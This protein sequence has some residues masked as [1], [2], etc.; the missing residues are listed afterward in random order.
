ML[1]P[2]RWAFLGSAAFLLIALGEILRQGELLVLALPLV[3]YLALG[4][5][6]ALPETMELRAQRRVSAQRVL[7]GEPVTVRVELENHGTN[8]EIVELVDNIPEIL[9]LHRPGSQKI[10]SLPSGGKIA[11]EYTVSGMRGLARWKGLSVLV[12]DTL[13]LF[14]RNMELSCEGE[15]LVVPRF[16]RIEEILMRPRRTR[17][18]SG[19]VKARLGGPGIE[20]FGVRE[21]YPGDERRY[22]NWKATARAARL[23][24]NE[25]EQE[26]VADVIIVLD[27][28]ER[29]DVF[30]KNLSLFEH[31]VRAALS[32]AYYFTGQGNRV[33]LLIYGK[34]LDWTWPGYGRWQREKLL[35]A[36]ASAEKGD[37][38]VF[39][40][41]ENLPTRLLPA[42]SQLV[43]VSPILESDVKTILEL[44]VRYEVLCI[45]P[46]PVLFESAFLAPTP[47][48]KLALRL[49]H[50]RR[51]ALLAY[52]RRAGIRVVDWD[53]ARPLAS[54]LKGEL[55][56]AAWRAALIR[57]RVL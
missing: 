17:I 31:S 51:Q 29:S 45:A 32:L 47:E 16:E 36:I 56:R 38:A 57:R 24:V 33:G 19:Q 13:G 22:I 43:F 20:F 40:D 34:Y 4:F 39:E 44:R 27:A 48:A 15:L 46:N 18:F 10:E 1:G 3:C 9:E 35:R 53:V 42:G 50:L 26:R 7:S 2:H 12:T 6:Y 21:Y 37:K 41:L 23:I 14:V 49:E 54:V 11:L 28:R 8:L 25:F 55:G 30:A 5:Y 52:L